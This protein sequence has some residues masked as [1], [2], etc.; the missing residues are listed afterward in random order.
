MSTGLKDRFDASITGDADTLDGYHYSDISSIIDTKQQKIYQA[1][2]AT[3]AATVAKTIT[4]TNW[5]PT[6]GDLLAV[7]FTLGS[8]VNSITLSVNGGTAYAIRINGISVNTTTHTLAANAV[9]LLFFDGTYWQSVGSQRVTDSD[10]YDRNRV[11]GAIQ[12]GVSTTRYKILAQSTDG[13]YYPLSI[14]DNTT[15]TNVASTT[16]YLITSPIVF[17]NST[18]TLADNSNSTN[19]YTSITNSYIQY[20]FNVISLTTY[21][22]VYIKAINNNDGTWCIDSSFLTQTLPTT[23]DGYLYILLGVVSSAQTTISMFEHNPIYEFKNGSI[24]PYSID[25]VLEYTNL[26]SFPTTGTSNKIYIA[27]DTNSQYRW[28]GSSYVGLSTSSS[29]TSWQYFFNA[30][31]V[32][33]SERYFKIATIS[34]PRD[35][36][37]RLYN[38]H[39]G[40]GFYGGQHW[41]DMNIRISISGVGTS[42]APTI[43]LSANGISKNA[44]VQYIHNTTTNLLEL[45]IFASSGSGAGIAGSFGISLYDSYYTN[46]VTIYSSG[47]MITSPSAT[48][49]P[50]ILTNQGG[51]DFTA[52]TGNVQT[53]LNSKANTTQLTDGSVTKVGTTSVGSAS[54]PIYLSSGTP[55]VCTT[56]N[57]NSKGLFTAG[58]TSRSIDTPVASVDGEY[59]VYR[60]NTPTGTVPATSSWWYVNEHRHNSTYYE[61]TMTDYFSNRSYHRI[62]NGGAWGAWREIAYTDSSITGNAA[63]AT[64]LATARTITLTGDATGSASFDGSANASIAVTSAHLEA[65]TGTYAPWQIKGSRGTY[66]GISAPGDLRLNFM[67]KIG[68]NYAGMYCETDSKWMVLRNADGTLKTDYSPAT[69]SNTTEIATTAFVNTRINA[70]PQEYFLSIYNSAST[71][72][73]T[74]GAFVILCNLVS[75]EAHHAEAVLS[76]SVCGNTTAANNYAGRVYMG[77]KTQG[78]TPTYNVQILEGTSNIDNLLKWRSD[79]GASTIYCTI[80]FAVPAYST[81]NVK[82]DSM[83]GGGTWS[84]GVNTALQSAWATYGT[85][86]T[87]SVPNAAKLGYSSV[88]SYYKPIYLNSG[89]PTEIESD[90]PAKFL[91]ST[92][93]S[94]SWNLYTLGYFCSIAADLIFNLDNAPRGCLLTATGTSVASY[95]ITLNRTSTTFYISGSTVA[96]SNTLRV[97]TRTLQFIIAPDYARVFI[98]GY[99]GN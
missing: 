63:T 17:Y 5:T 82:I 25:S 53:Q 2:C 42:T 95:S 67:S 23:E 33:D 28:N 69:T 59:V 62:M 19:F 98:I 66:S 45:Y 81:L 73:Y 46:Y 76:F 44:S 8:S 7:T 58:Y 47:S 86:L 35:G 52:L 15:S 88:G 32:S 61:Q 34:A 94:N 27:A 3:A 26:A 29:S 21:K 55:T 91:Y 72:M 71:M 74:T 75:T 6:S 43:T 11:G 83:T 31:Y 37:Y 65:N 49:I 20:T 89:N 14:G 84:S 51:T 39:I 12:V 78:T 41:L 16:K 18:T 99:Y 79:Q 30:T 68:G 38:L 96:Y 77:C 1:T 10:T 90:V 93:A 97:N 70:Q 50:I 87:Y 85:M 22:A 40:K 9:L 57:L 36:T 48:T 80:M 64:K 24:R 4:V 92:S 56:V 13:F 60:S 54:V